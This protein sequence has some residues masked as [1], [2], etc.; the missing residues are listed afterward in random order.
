MLTFKQSLEN[1][2]HDHH[3]YLSENYP[4]LNLNRFC[5]EAQ[6]YL[7]INK[8]ASNLDNIDAL[9][10]LNDFFKNILEGVPLEYIVETGYFYKH[11]FYVNYLT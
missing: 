2:F 3:H 1:F 6:D 11:S 8:I 4:G 7:K 10:S 9:A 5:E